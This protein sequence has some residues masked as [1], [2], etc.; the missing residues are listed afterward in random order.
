MDLSGT[1]DDAH[2]HVRVLIAD[3]HA[4]VRR[5]LRLLIDSHP[6]LSVIEDV[7]DGAAAIQSCIAQ[8]PDVALLDVNMPV[9]GGITATSEIR[10][11]APGTGVVILTYQMQVSVIRAALVAGAHGFVL[12]NSAETEL[13]DAIEAA[14]RGERYIA[15]RAAELVIDTV[16]HT[17]PADAQIS[18][19][20]L[21]GISTRERQV[22]QMLA[23]G[24]PN[25]V[26][27]R[28]LNLSAKTVET[29]RSR[30]MHKL[31]VRSFAELIRLA[32]RSGLVDQDG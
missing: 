15:Q 17:E 7:G 2:T 28:T 19:T 30:L 22:L 21:R 3:D 10:S 20:S 1:P 29:Y 11:A 4:L 12:K 14:S 18:Q 8:R 27:A 23:E 24:V 32:V 5:G 13:F 6:R 25:P 9:T 26:I 31:N 16:I